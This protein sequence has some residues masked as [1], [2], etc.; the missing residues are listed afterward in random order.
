MFEVSD[1][2]ALNRVPSSANGL[3]AHPVLRMAM[4]A[5]GLCVDRPTPR[6]SGTRGERIHRFHHH[7][8]GQSGFFAYYIRHCVRNTLHRGYYLFSFT[9]H[10]VS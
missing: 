9:T 2:F 6:A 4:L 1:Q 8:G 3:L 5:D 10:V 7:L